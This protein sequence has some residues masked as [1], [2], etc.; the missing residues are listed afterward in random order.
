M[1][2]GASNMLLQVS[3]ELAR[4]RPDIVLVHGDRFEVFPV[5]QAAYYMNIPVAH[6]EGGEDSGCIDNGIRHM[7]SAISTYDFAASDMALQALIRMGKKKAFFVGSTGIDNLVGADLSRPLK[8]KYVLV[9][10]HPDTNK[11]Q[12]SVEVEDEMIQIKSLV[13]SCP[14]KV[15]WINPNFDAGSKNL[16]HKIH[17]ECNRIDNITFLKNLHP[18]Q[19][20]RYLANCEV[21]IGNSSSFIKEGNY[22]GVPVVLIGD[23]QMNR[24]KGNNVFFGFSD[25]I[26]NA[27]KYDSVRVCKCQFGSGNAGEQIADILGAENYE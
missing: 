4:L 19:Y 16:L 3:H 20:Y 21:A 10:Y 26:L 27:K 25:Y 14:Y 18:Y 24:E 1:V 23:R 9:L 12:E 11:D 2:I 13:W 15:V 7:I 22:L 6:S 17:N 8:E 5:A